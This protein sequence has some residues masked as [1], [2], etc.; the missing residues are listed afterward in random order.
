MDLY[1]IFWNSVRPLTTAIR[2]FTWRSFHFRW[3]E[4]RCCD[5]TDNVLLTLAYF[6]LL[7]VPFFLH[8]PPVFFLCMLRSL[9]RSILNI[10]ICFR[11]KWRTENGAQERSCK[12]A[13]AGKIE[14]ERKQLKRLADVMNESGMWAMRSSTIKSLQKDFLPA[15]IIFAPV[16]TFVSRRPQGLD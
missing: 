12:T 14:R 11:K 15:I 16:V 9:H 4:E 5:P 2:C 8:L 10:I 6:S 7:S 13:D 1:I 3:L